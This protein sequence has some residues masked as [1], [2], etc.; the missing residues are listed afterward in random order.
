[1]SNLNE[2]TGGAIVERMGFLLPNAMDGGFDADDLS[3]D[4]EGLQISF[5]RVKIPGGGVLQFE[6]LS[7]DPDA[8][9]TDTVSKW[10]LFKDVSLQRTHQMNRLYKFASMLKGRL[11]VCY[12]D[13]A[14]FWP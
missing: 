5:P 13:L 12:N 14:L 11:H 4:M 1:M 6:M 7:D 8:Q 3:E 9:T 2:Q 10:K